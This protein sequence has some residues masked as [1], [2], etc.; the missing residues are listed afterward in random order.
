[1]MLCC[2]FAEGD[3]RILMQKMAR[4]ELKQAQKRGLL[5]LFR[6]SVLQR[7]PVLRNKAVKTLQ[8][9]RALRAAPSMAIGF[10]REYEMVYALA[11]SICAA[12]V[13]QRPKGEEVARVLKQ[14]PDLLLNLQ[15]PLL[16]SRL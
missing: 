16:V 10:E 5:S 13:H 3:S 7:D 4:D 1:M 14:H 12:H 11:D 15:Q 2:K 6:E 8:L 9:A